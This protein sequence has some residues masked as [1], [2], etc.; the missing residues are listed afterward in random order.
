MQVR[1]LFFATLK[2]I[3]GARQLQLDLPSGSTI[4]DLLTQLLIT[5]PEL[6]GSLADPAALERRRTRGELRAAF[7]EVFAPGATASD[8]RDRLRR[9]K[10][11][12][13][14]TIVWRYLLGATSIEGYSLE[15][16][17]LA[18][19]DG[20]SMEVAIACRVDQVEKLIPLAIDIPI[21]MQSQRAQIQVP[22]VASW[23]LSERFRWSAGE[24]L[25]VS[26]R[27][28]SG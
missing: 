26:E 17:P 24:V 19:L 13:E 11:A 6:L 15:I 3:V 8:R 25:L 28:K 7:A 12:Q 5:Q 21:G 20:Q 27:R 10:Q 16:S 9:I 2:D 14:L 18:S 4:G 23:R 22:Q 1:L